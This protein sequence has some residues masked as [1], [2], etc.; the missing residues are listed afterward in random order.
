[1]V[2]FKVDKDI[3]KLDDRTCEYVQKYY[4]FELQQQAIRAT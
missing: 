2:C 3:L 1:M 4:T